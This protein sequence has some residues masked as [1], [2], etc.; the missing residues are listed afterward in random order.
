MD[1][2]DLVR[3][4]VEELRPLLGF[5]ASPLLAKLFRWTGASPQYTVG[6]LDRVDAI[7][8][9]VARHAGLHLAGAA[10][11]GVGI[12]DC[13]RQGIQTADRVLD[14]IEKKV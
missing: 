5:T 1:D 14:A 3:L 12:P 8:S 11:R 10:Y 6:H 13:I 2:A 4:V 9:A 7:E